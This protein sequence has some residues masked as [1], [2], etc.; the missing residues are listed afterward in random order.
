MSQFITTTPLLDMRPVGTPAERSLPRLEAVLGREFKDRIG[1]RLAEPIERRDGAGIDWYVDN[2][3]DEALARLKDL[4]EDLAAYYKKRFDADVATIGE[5]ARSYEARNDQAARSTAAALRNAICY[6][7]EDHLWVMGDARSGKASV[8]VTAWGYE[9]RTSELTGSHAINRRE[10]FFPDSAQVLIDQTP[11]TSE[12]VLAKAIA[13]ERP[14]SLISMLTAALW[15]VALLLPLIIGWML[16]PACGLKVPFMQSYIYGWGDGAFCKQLPN[17]QIQ[18]GSSLVDTS[19]AELTG[20]K[21][22]LRT[23]IFQ[24]V[25]VAQAEAATPP[26]QDEHLIQAEGLDVDP[27]E[28]SVSLTWNNT[29]DL[30]LY[31]VCPDGVR[32][33]LEGSRCG[34]RH[35]IDKNQTGSSLVA[36]PVEYIRLENGV[37]QSG[38][39]KVEVVYFSNNPPSPLA[40]PFTVSLRRNGVKTEYPATTSSRQ[41]VTGNKEMIAVTEFT[42]Q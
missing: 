29:N 12:A 39:Y 41:P 2:E 19:T 42:V 8:V 6:P 33:P 32:V 10:R 30:D 23:K 35:K 27:N 34:F 24:C 3:N 20:L 38:T 13:M 7:G 18:L 31:L 22:Q 5:A 25:R 14:R 4:P 17:A 9:P 16:L 1:M 37:L 26:S 21:D 40:T 11:T 36:D 28:T 15:V